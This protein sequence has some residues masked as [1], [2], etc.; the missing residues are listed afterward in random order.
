MNYWLIDYFLNMFDFLSFISLSPK[1]FFM[2]TRNKKVYFWKHNKT[3]SDAVF[4]SFGNIFEWKQKTKMLFIFHFFPTFSSSS[5]VTSSSPPTSHVLVSS[6]LLVL[7]ISFGVH[8]TPLNL[9]WYQVSTHTHINLMKILTFIHHN[10]CHFVVFW[11]FCEQKKRR[12]KHNGI[13]TQKHNLNC[14]YST[15]SNHCPWSSVIRELVSQ[16]SPI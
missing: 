1:M 6:H 5:Q 4:R 12:K 10:Q 13:K 15:D 2:K 8:I 9:Y 7:S 14:Y 16:L 3:I 11:A